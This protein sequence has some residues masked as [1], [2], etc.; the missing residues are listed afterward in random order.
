MQTIPWQKIESLQKEIKALKSLGKTK[1]S[2]TATRR[3]KPSSIEG[4]LKG[5]DFTNE[6]IEEAKKIWFNE[7]HILYQKHSK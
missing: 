4:I 5:I 2:K 3:A 1:P 7:D 6:E